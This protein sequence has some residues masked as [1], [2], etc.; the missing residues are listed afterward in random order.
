MR[1]E[2]PL[3]MPVTTV[4][5]DA[6]V[7]S[8]KRKFLTDRHYD[9]LISREDGDVNVLKPD[10]S[11][12]LLFRP[13]SLSADVCL[14]AL[15]ALELAAKPTDNRGTAAGSRR[16]V[17]RRRDG[18]LSKILRAR[19]VLSGEIGYADR[20]PRLGDI[21]RTT[22]YTLA[23]WG[24]GW[25]QILPFVRAI[26]DV[27]RQAHQERYE[28]QRELVHRTSQ[29]FVI[30]GTAFTTV[31]VNRN[32]QTA[33]HK[34]KGDLKEGFGVMSVIERGAYDGCYLCFPKYSIAVDMRTTDVLLADVHEWHGNSPIIGAPGTYDRIA[35]VLYYRSKMRH[36]GTAEEEYARA[37]RRASR[38]HG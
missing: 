38:R 35:T 32:F 13:N 37:K 26:D 27:F 30:H 11:P 33:V 16:Y 36:C 29:D 23:E 10:G 12:L 5:S 24:R 9:R 18:T 1:N 17:K 8:Y 7:N 2:D 19:T 25:Q 28:V 4:L 22:A 14:R 15:P 31:T 3:I 20:S 34:D 6:L 21:C